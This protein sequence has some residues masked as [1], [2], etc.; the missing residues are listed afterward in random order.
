L[1][2][3]LC[4]ENQTI[5]IE[6]LNISGMLKNHKLAQAIS[7][8]S[9]SKFITYLKYK[10]EWY[11]VNII[12][13]GRFEPSSKMCSNCGN[14]Y[15]ELSLKERKWKCNNC[16][17]EHDRDINAAKNIKQFGLIRYDRYKNYIGSERPDSKPVENL[18]PVNKACKS[19]VSKLK[20]M[21]QEASAFR[22][23]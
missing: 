8:V 13:I 18:T 20:S 4:S 23:K 9:W 21:K 11:G 14:I 22:Q 15:K 3:Q 2:T 17:I 10:S 6:D 16:K 5:I 7:D 12:E 1:T 19:G